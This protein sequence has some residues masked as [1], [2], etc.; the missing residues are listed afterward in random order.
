MRR[1]RIEVFF[2][3]LL[4]IIGFIVGM[5]I[6]FSEDD[7]GL[8]IVKWSNFYDGKNIHF[9]YGSSEK[10][11]LDS[12]KET[13]Q[14]E[15]VVGEEKNDFN[16]SIKLMK[17]VKDKLNY[18][19]GTKSSNEE[20][21]AAD[22]LEKGENNKKKKYYSNE[23]CTTVFNECAIA[24]GITSRIGEVIALD[25]KKEK[26]S[27]KV[28]EIWSNEYKKWIMIDASNGCYLSNKGVPLSVVEIIEKGIDN[29]QVEG[30]E[31]SKKYKKN[32]GKLLGMYTVPIDNSIYG[33]KSSNSY[34]VFLKNDNCMQIPIDIC[35]NYPVIFT[36][37]SILFNISPHNKFV[38]KK[39]DKIPTL[40]FAKKNSKE[41]NNETQFY[42]GVFQDSI[43]IKKYY[44]SIN[45]SPFRE[46]NNYFDFS[47]KNGIN[48]VKLS[49]DGKNVVRE[50]TFELKEK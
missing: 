6:K 12:L 14:L 3:C 17:W 39:E 47:V 38:D 30:I 2:I 5:K 20:V 48:A 43:M 46:V 31:N 41:N 50:A 35:M 10:S 26:E 44:I 11:I 4:I 19:Y 22:I 24:L 18:K 13:Y 23:E 27:F 33:R 29:F 7:S 25:N 49:I 15:I 45:D 40:I 9:Y 8:R 32:I 42:G 36:K 16:K 37:D 1:K 21:G 34:V 28:C